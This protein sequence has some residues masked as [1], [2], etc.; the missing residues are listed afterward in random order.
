[1]HRAC[2]PELAHS[3]IETGRSGAEHGIAKLFGSTGLTAVGGVLAGSKAFIH[4]AWRWKHRLGGAAGHFGD[5]GIQAR[6]MIFGRN[7]CMHTRTIGNAAAAEIAPRTEERGD[8]LRHLGDGQ[9]P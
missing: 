3:G 1:M 4:E 5:C 9:R 6:R 8:L 7:H 2:G